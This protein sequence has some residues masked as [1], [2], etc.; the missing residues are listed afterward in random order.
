MKKFLPLLLLFAV[1]IWVFNACTD[2]RIDGLLN[3]EA[4]YAE[5]EDFND[6]NQFGED[7]K[8]EYCTALAKKLKAAKEG[9]AEYD[10]LMK[11]WKEKCGD[12]DDDIDCDQLKRKIA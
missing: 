9:T 12:K 11:L 10:R 6:L 3:N 8:D 1:S 7:E 2:S 5:S 4:K